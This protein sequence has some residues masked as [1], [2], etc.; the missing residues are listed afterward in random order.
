MLVKG[1]PPAPQPRAL[2]VLIMYPSFHNVGQSRHCVSV[3]ALILAKTD[4]LSQC[5][6]QMAAYALSIVPYPVAP[7][8]PDIPPMHKAS[9]DLLD[10]LID[11]FAV[12]PRD[13]CLVDVV[14]HLKGM[15]PD[16]CLDH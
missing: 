1:A 4:Q 2:I 5:N 3:P 7:R 14:Q 15:Q 12:F 8:A 9:F 13:G 16:V 11:L 10:G 6:E